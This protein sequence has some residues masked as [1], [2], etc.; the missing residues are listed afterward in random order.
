MAAN[1]RRMRLIPPD[2]VPLVTEEL[3][4]VT[5][6]TQWVRVAPSQ[7]EELR[8]I[9]LPIVPVTSATA[10]VT[11]LRQLRDL[12]SE[13]DVR[14]NLGTLDGRRMRFTSAQTPTG[15]RR[16]IDNCVNANS[17]CCNF[18]S[19][20]DY[21]WC[22]SL[23]KRVTPDGISVIAYADAPPREG[24][25]DDIYGLADV[26]DSYTTLPPRH[27]GWMMNRVFEFIT[28]F[29]AAQV[30]LG[31]T[32]PVLTRL[33][34]YN[35]W[36][37]RKNHGILITGWENATTNAV[38]DDSQ[39]PAPY[40][41]LARL[42]KVL[43]FVLWGFDERVTNADAVRYKITRFL[44]ICVDAAN[45]ENPFEVDFMHKQWK[46]LL[47]QLFGKPEFV[48]FDEQLQRAYA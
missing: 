41:M 14:T 27:M 25:W 30:E 47:K 44:T 45:K 12:Q 18:H 9:T 16:M 29:S 38:D 36:V 1:R 32:L 42:S 19:I 11:D 39:R 35:V 20:N 21:V 8:E 34:G 2:P 17:V 13:H 7:Y 31:V 3:N 40:V 23:Y 33:T 10:G 28:L 37:N 5:P 4:V 24:T 48:D 26:V 46:L 43:G 22:P 15:V 6:D